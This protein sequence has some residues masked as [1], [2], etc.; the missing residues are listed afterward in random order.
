[1]NII[2]LDSRFDLSPAQIS[3]TEALL[4]QLPCLTPYHGYHD[5]LRELHQKIPVY[6]LSPERMPNE[7]AILEGKLDLRQAYPADSIYPMDR[8]ASFPEDTVKEG[9][10]P[11]TE[12]L[13]FYAHKARLLNVETP[14]IA[15]CPE[16]IMRC[17]STQDEL[18]FLI[19]MVWIH[20]LFHAVLAHYSQNNDQPMDEF[21]LWMEE[22]LVN[23]MTLEVFSLH[24]SLCL[25]SDL[26]FAHA[27]DPDMAM[28]FVVDFISLQPPYYR[29]GK[30]LFHRRLIRYALR[31][32][33]LGVKLPGRHSEKQAWLDYVKQHLGR[34][35][36]ETL[37]GLYEALYQ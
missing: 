9:A 28:D 17:V 21:Y 3:F 19:A 27:G 29:F 20:E 5:L 16:R 33:R 25:Q 34:T 22:S 15:I 6:L 7:A 13:G 1:M 26:A 4:L 18:I 23:A 2:N 14:V 37:K 36:R 11:S 24:H 35:D 8:S 10:R 32:T 12:W 30:D 31:W